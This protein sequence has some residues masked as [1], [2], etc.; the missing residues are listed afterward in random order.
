MMAYGVIR[1]PIGGTNDNEHRCSF[2]SSGCGQGFD[3]PSRKSLSPLRAKGDRLLP[4]P[5]RRA[6]FS[7]VRPGAVHH[8]L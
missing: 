1:K 4:Y 7:A 6:A 3:D 5:G 2:A 8:Q